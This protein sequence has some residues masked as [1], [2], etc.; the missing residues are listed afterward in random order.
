[1]STPSF[2]CFLILQIKL[3]LVVGGVFCHLKQFCLKGGAIEAG[4]VEETCQ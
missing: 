3:V 2:C 1:M 4:P